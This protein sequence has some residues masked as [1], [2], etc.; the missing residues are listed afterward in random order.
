M[1]STSGPQASRSKGDATGSASSGAAPGGLYGAGS[2]GMRGNT[3]RTSEP[4][5]DVQT[6]S[7]DVRRLRAQVQSLAVDIQLHETEQHTRPLPNVVSWAQAQYQILPGPVKGMLAMYTAMFLI[8]AFL[9]L[10]RSILDS[11]RRRN[12]PPLPINIRPEWPSA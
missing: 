11:L 12:A 8:G 2:T 9:R 5:T 4:T 7:G 3:D 1:E 6:L 10:I